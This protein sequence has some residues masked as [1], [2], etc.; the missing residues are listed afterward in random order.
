MR[1]AVV[2]L[3]PELFQG[4]LTI[5]MVGRALASGAIS[6]LMRSPREFGLGR[7]RS[8]DDT[9]YGGGSGMV[10]RVD[11]IVRCMEALE[12]GAAEGEAASAPPGG[13][14]ASAPPGGEAA[15]APPGG[16]A[17]SAPPGGEAVAPP[18]PAE[19]AHRILLT[20]QGQ[21]F[22]QEKAIELAAR[23]S[24]ALVCGRYEG[25]DE[26]VRAFVDEE[27]SLGDF[28]MTGGEVAAMAV[29]DA[30]VRLLPGVLGNA[31]SAEH[32]SHSPALSGL[33]EYPQYTRPVEFRGLKVPEVLQ[34]G[35]HAA[36]ARWRQEQ[37]EQRTAERR[38]DLWRKARGGDA[39]PD[40][41][42]EAR[43]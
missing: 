40:E 1:I 9:P 22:R 33:L 36:I 24:I 43:R 41:R 10:M 8:V 14:A 28:V 37:A 42:D 19:R 16:E 6:V 17:A 38:P 35:N 20:P 31:G 27:I 7:H 4:F 5:G 12:E 39:A 11:C 21:P 23:P 2:T 32:E 34:Q 3:F 30:C 15:S 13:E 18:G 29:I 25:F 26:R